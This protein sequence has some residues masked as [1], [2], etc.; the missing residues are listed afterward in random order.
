MNKQIKRKKIKLMFVNCLTKIR[1]MILFICSVNIFTG[2]S[3][4]NN[5]LE[6]ELHSERNA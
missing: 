5:Y 6:N 4:K 1:L 3:E 2:K